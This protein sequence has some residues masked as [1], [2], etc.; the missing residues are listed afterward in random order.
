[1]PEKCHSALM[2]LKGVPRRHRDIVNGKYS[3]G[4][5]GALM[6]TPLDN[7][8]TSKNGSNQQS[9]DGLA[10]KETVKLPEVVTA[11]SSVPVT[12]NGGPGTALA[13]DATD[14]SAAPVG[15]PSSGVTKP[16]VLRVDDIREGQNDVVK[17]YAFRSGEYAVFRRKADDDVMVLFADDPAVGLDQRKRVLAMGTT[18]A[19]LNS[20]LTDWRNRGVYDRKIAYALQLALDGD[21]DGGKATLLSAKTELLAD[22][23]A[24]GRFQYLKWALGAGAIMLV[25][26]FAASHVYRFTDPSSN[27]WL[28]AKAGLIGAGFSIALG[29]RRRTVALDLNP[30]DNISD[31]ILRLGIGVV[32]A[33]TLLMLL[34]SGLLPSMELNGG[35]DL[36][37]VNLTGGKMTWQVVIVIGFIGGF[38]ERLVPDLLE[39]RAPAPL[40]AGSAEKPGAGGANGR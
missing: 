3:L 1:M 26:L 28:A 33:G 24:A 25:L 7:D 29:I 23:S 22:R 12:G 39:K 15:R 8:S 20:L 35:T 21:A 37:G 13:A 10:T 34:S 2:R 4:I 14:A 32:A 27:I 5:E 6:A 30:L 19:E 31:G 16:P 36:K 18:R 40:T 38:L 9:K 11:R 17:V